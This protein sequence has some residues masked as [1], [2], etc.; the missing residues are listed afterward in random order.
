[1]SLNSIPE[2]PIA[3]KGPDLMSSF[4]EKQG[5][6]TIG[7]ALTPKSDNGCV[8]P[9]VGVVL[10]LSVLRETTNSGFVFLLRLR[11]KIKTCWDGLDI[12][13][14]LPQQGSKAIEQ[15]DQ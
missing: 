15:Y 10:V 11:Q 8:S 2:I 13:A 4:D 3:V 7:C 5:I 14:R 1:M 9:S 12:T 6:L